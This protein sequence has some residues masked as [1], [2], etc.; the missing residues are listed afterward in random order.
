MKPKHL[1]FIILTPALLATLY[2]LADSQNL[3]G[4]FRTP[5]PTATSTPT[6]TPTATPTATQTP[7][8]TATNT[9]VPPTPTKKGGERRKN[10][11]TTKSSRDGHAN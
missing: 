7:T 8:P 4:L 2:L 11:D 10:S 5:T 6:F 3:G 9:P 1:L